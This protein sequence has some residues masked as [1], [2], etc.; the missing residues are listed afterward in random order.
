MVRPVLALLGLVSLGAL[1]YLAW[2]GGHGDVGN[3]GPSSPTLDR[4]DPT[5][6]QPSPSRP[7]EGAQVATLDFDRR[8][9][10]V[11]S[12]GQVPKL[13]GT[14]EDPTGR[15][16]PGGLVRAAQV[17]GTQEGAVHFVEGRTSKNGGFAFADLKPGAWLVQALD[18]THSLARPEAVVV[19]ATGAVELRLRLAPG[20]TV[21][22]RAQDLGGRPL[23]GVP[24]TLHWEDGTPDPHQVRSGTTDG[25]G[26]WT[27]S[28]PTLPSR[29]AVRTTSATHFRAE[30]ASLHVEAAKQ[31]MVVT[32][33]PKR[34][35]EG[36]VVDEQG[37]PVG[38]ARLRL[39]GLPCVA[40]DQGRF[41]FASV[42]AMPGRVVILAGDPPLRRRGALEVE[43]AEL[44]TISGL[45][46]RVREQSCIVGQI[47][48]RQGRPVAD[49]TVHAQG[50]SQSGRARKGYVE[51]AHHVERLSHV[52]LLLGTGDSV[53]RRSEAARQDLARLLA[54]GRPEPVEEIQAWRA[55]AALIDLNDALVRAQHGGAEQP[56]TQK[57]LRVAHGVA[58][59][60]SGAGFYTLG[61]QVDQSARISA[62]G[63]IYG[64]SGAGDLESPQRSAT[65]DEQ[66]RF[67]IFGLVP[68]T[69][70]VSPSKADW[71]FL[72]EPASVT[73]EREGEEHQRDFVLAEGAVVEFVLPPAVAGAAQEKASVVIKHRS[74]DGEEEQSHDSAEVLTFAGLPAGTHNFGLRRGA[75]EIAILDPISLDY[76]DRVRRTVTFSAPGRITVDVTGPGGSP[77]SGGSVR[78]VGGG[79]I[80]VDP[81]LSTNEAGQAV[82]SPLVSGT[83]EIRAAGPGLPEVSSG[84]RWL[85]SG[86]EET[87]AIS[88][89]RGAVLRGRVV[90][91]AGRPEQGLRVFLRV[92]KERLDTDTDSEGEFT[93]EGV[94][95][96]THP[97]HIRSEDMET[98]A[99]LEVTTV[100]GADQQLKIIVRPSLSITGSL[101]RAPGLPLGG[102]E[103]IAQGETKADI[104]RTTSTASD[105]SFSLGKLYPGTYQLRISEIAADPLRFTVGYDQPPP[106][107]SVREKP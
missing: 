76:G 18:A 74:D 30:S 42:E 71:F 16:V 39:L 20:A 40:D 98:S 64:A 36:V 88:L 65:T 89:R 33:A 105:G 69:Y 107:L 12:H 86:A 94:P 67:E 32:L 15:P 62:W 52:R 8:P 85:A 83:Y 45:E 68:G 34:N 102:Y 57:F 4:A 26:A 53:V 60:T 29:W 92:P 19:P 84:P 38:C 73:I 51:L 9:E 70:R 59:E 43:V 11:L 95:D 66:G 13:L 103:V 55:E 37:S 7:E 46:I 54:E 81:E 90:D 106:I 31:D 101:K 97:L 24:L 100:G 23:A 93:I 104:R 6:M 41:R 3:E 80:F 28:G 1:A 91:P 75:N 78:I 22:L 50:R 49:A 63:E 17:R 27:L 61:S 87:V 14:L 35:L 25:Q 72:D 58:A 56:S 10:A 2:P 5:P 44:P 47:L 21:T 48:D 96:G 82:F 99:A 79:G 77:V